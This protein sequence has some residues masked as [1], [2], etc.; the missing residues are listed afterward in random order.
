M[1]S[2]KKGKECKIRRKLKVQSVEHE[3]TLDIDL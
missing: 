3:S 1:N 2:V